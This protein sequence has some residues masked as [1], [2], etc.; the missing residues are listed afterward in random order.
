M[1]QP[2]ESRYLL[3]DY[4]A[5]EKKK[6]PIDGV[7]YEVTLYQGEHSNEY[8]L[9]EMKDG[10]VEGRCQLFN[11]GIL[12]LAW[13]V[14]N[15]K[16]IGEITEY[17][18]GKALRKESW[19][20]ILGN[21]GGNRRMIEN[22]IEGLIM[23]IRRT[24]KN[25][26]DNHVIYRGEF[27][28]EMNR[29][30]YGMEY[31]TENGKERIEGYW[32]K[33]KLIRVTR[34]FDADNNQMIEYSIND[35]KDNV[36][37][38]SRIPIYIGG[39]CI[40]NGKYVRNGIGY[41]IDEKS[42]AAIRESEWE[43]GKEKKESGI[44]LYEG[45]YVKGMS[46]S[47]RN[48][49]K[50]ENP[51]EMKTEPVVNVPAKRIEI[52]NI[53]EM[54]NTDLNVADLLICSNTCNELKELGLN[55]F[56]GL[57]SIEIGDDCFESVQIFQ[58]NGLNRLKSLIIGKRSFT[59]KKKKYGNDSSKSFHILNCE[60]LESTQIGEYSFSDFAGEFELRNLPKLQSIEIGT[61]KRKSY[62]FYYSSFVIRGIEL[63]LNIV[64][65][66][67]SKSTIHYIG[68]PNIRQFLINN[69]GKY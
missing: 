57:E 21:D 10:K 45:W 42:G 33:D 29:D 49:L 19:N 66:R 54:N 62:N 61:N 4:I 41:L 23:T 35:D 38:L 46:E 16:R 28:E 65:I 22:S 20:S 68:R 56:E 50:H 9:S 64:M 34:E 5:R 43:N 36:D 59:Q 67:S 51:C 15:G 18:N 24:C 52:H 11:R 47:I 44:D 40:M 37:L 63:I 58:I 25:G 55:R 2:R 6:I 30:G 1:K 8:L 17:E 3:S 13:M 48:I 12:S 14:N 39:Y 60:S 7:E 53:S 69:N 27:D 32:S 26:E 31:D